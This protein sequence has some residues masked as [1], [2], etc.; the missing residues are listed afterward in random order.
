MN[1]VEKLPLLIKQGSNFSLSFFKGAHN[2]PIYSVF[3]PFG[4]G[5]GIQKYSTG[6][7]I[8]VGMGT[9]TS[10]YADFVDFLAK[11]LLLDHLK[12]TDVE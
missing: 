12:K 8:L 6:K 11:K 1:R 5:L 10:C 2:K 7:H 9:A 4:N 3:G